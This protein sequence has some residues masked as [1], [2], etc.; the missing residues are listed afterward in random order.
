MKHR[1]QKPSNSCA[2][3]PAVAPSEGIA[4]SQVSSEDCVDHIVDIEPE[5][6]NDSAVDITLSKNC[7]FVDL[8]GDIAVDS[9]NGRVPSSAGNQ[10]SQ[11]A[12]HKSSDEKLVEVAAVAADVPSQVDDVCDSCKDEDDNELGTNLAHIS[13]L[14][15][16]EF[17]I[18]LKSRCSTPASLIDLYS[19]VSFAT[20]MVS[21]LNY[22]VSEEDEN[23]VPDDAA[24][25]SRSKVKNLTDEC[26]DTAAV[27]SPGAEVPSAL[28][29]K[30]MKRQQSERKRARKAVDKEYICTHSYTDVEDQVDEDKLVNLLS[31]NEEMHSVHSPR[32][33]VTP[34]LVSGNPIFSTTGQPS[35]PLCTQ[36]SLDVRNVAGSQMEERPVEF[37]SF[38]VQQLSNH[39]AECIQLTPQENGTDRKQTEDDSMVCTQVASSGKKKKSLLLKKKTTRKQHKTV[40]DESKASLLKRANITEEHVSQD[41]ACYDFALRQSTAECHLSLQHTSIE[42]G[43]CAEAVELPELND[44]TLTVHSENH[45]QLQNFSDR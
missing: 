26:H 33:T 1:K 4:F 27:E 8:E 40:T 17:V 45:C 23:V 34:E 20:D 29:K 16:P 36:Q 35:Q 19:D 15:T 11:A 41:S 21:L 25:F 32:V 39:D 43:L 44:T 6:M 3:M 28:V 42:P 14:S 5:E 7:E 30:D 12:D 24:M 38:P 31:D 2:Q 9:A 10:P 37:Y 18:G 13:L 22:D